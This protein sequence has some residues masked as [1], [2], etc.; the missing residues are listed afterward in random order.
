MVKIGIRVAFFGVG[1][2]I[3]SC[4]ILHA[5]TADE[6]AMLERGRAAVTDIR[7]ITDSAEPLHLSGLPQLLADKLKESKGAAILTLEGKP[8]AGAYLPIWTWHT[9]DGTPLVEFPAIGYRGVL[10]QR[11]DAFATITANLPG[12]SGQW[13]SNEWFR[14]HVKKSKFPP[15]FFGPAILFPMNAGEIG[16]MSIRDWRRHLA[17]VASVRF[18]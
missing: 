2:A 15:T 18:N 14:T 9:K 17:L 12:I 7:A 5:Q 4:S 1:L 3:A 8:G 6:A 16:A 13:F 11:P 10:G